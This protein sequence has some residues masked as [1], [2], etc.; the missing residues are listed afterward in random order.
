MPSRKLTVGKGEPGTAAMQL[1][2]DKTSYATNME[3]YQK[4]LKQAINIIKDKQ[5]DSRL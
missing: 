5:E 1:F 2:N 3:S 4:L